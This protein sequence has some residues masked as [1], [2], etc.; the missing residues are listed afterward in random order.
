M[1][2]QAWKTVGG[3]YFDDRKAAEQHEAEYIN[4]VDRSYNQFVNTSFSGRQLLKKHSLNERGTWKVCGE[5]ANA[6]LAGPHHAPYLF[7]ATG[8]LESVIRKAVEHPCFFSWGGG[9]EITKIDIVELD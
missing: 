7:T 3:E 8:T 2:I 5:D 4:N 9:G 6:D 1:P